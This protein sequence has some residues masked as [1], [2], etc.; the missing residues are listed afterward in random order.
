MRITWL[1]DSVKM[2]HEVGV[3]SGSRNFKQVALW[4]SRSRLLR[5]LAGRFC[6]GRGQRLRL[7]WAQD[8]ELLSSN[9]KEQLA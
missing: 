5:G 4:L 6:N 7:I 3:E 9:W 8:S 2:M 1:R